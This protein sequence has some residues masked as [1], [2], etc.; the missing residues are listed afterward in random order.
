MMIWERIVAFPV[1]MGG[2]FVSATSSHILSNFLSLC[3]KLSSLS[4]I[5]HVNWFSHRI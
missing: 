5:F 4:L 2:N 3:N 1:K